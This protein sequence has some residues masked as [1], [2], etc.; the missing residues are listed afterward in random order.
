M[1]RRP[2]KLVIFGGVVL[3][4]GIFASVT[5][6]AAVNNKAGLPTATFSGASVSVTGGDF[7]GL[8]NTPA[9]ATLTAAGLATYTCTNP[10]GHASPGQNPVAAQ[11]GSSGP[12]QLPTD[13]NGR[14]TIGTLSTTV[15]APA[16]PTAQ[17]AG[18]GGSGSTQ[19]T[20]TLKTLT[21]TSANLT[22]TH[23]NPGPV[24]FCR[25]YT[26]SGTGTAC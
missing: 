3:F 14:A 23:G 17:Q 11:G 18:C 12:V 10:Q 21:A 24:I 7:S 19:W 8:G 5:A 20:V 15:T 22:I 9:F 25:N 16:T 2:R 6:M 13:K 26:S 4:F 1:R